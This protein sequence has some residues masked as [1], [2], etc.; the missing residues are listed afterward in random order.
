MRLFQRSASAELFLTTLSRY[1]DQSHYELHGFVVMPDH[2]HLLL[3]PSASLEATVGLIKGGFSFAVRKQYNGAVWQ[4]GYYSHRVMDAADYASQFAYI[5]AKSG[6]QAL[7]RIRLC[8]HEL[9]GPP[10]SEAATSR[11]LKP[12]GF[13]RPSI[14]AAE[15]ACVHLLPS[16]DRSRHLRRGRESYVCRSHPL[17]R[18][19]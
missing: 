6:A 15:A 17:S 18:R 9:L 10:G 14:S 11:R 5:A 12:R 19:I 2:S 13:D 3:S 1:R 8:T 16:V 4:E 7:Q